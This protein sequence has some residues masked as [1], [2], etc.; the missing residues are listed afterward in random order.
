MYLWLVVGVVVVVVVVL[1]ALGRGDSAATAQPDGRVAYLPDDRPVT[2]DDVDALRLPQA[3]RGYRVA[4]V[5][6]VLDRLSA[7]LRRRDVLLAGLG[8]RGAPETEVPGSRAAGPGVDGSGDGP[9]ASTDRDGVG[10]TRSR[11]QLA[12]P[13]PATTDQAD[14]ADDETSGPGT[15]S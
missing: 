13:L 6:D 14:D 3:V 11:V 9:A 2:P 12:V 4:D 10:P 8:V 7:E 5:D 1:V 15:S